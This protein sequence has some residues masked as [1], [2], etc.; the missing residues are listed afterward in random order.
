MAKKRLNPSI[1]RSRTR[2]GCLTCRDRHMKCDE[3]QPVCRNCIKSKRKCYRGIRLN[4]TQYTIYNPRES[5]DYVSSTLSIPTSTP[6]F[7]ILDQSIT[8]ASLYQDGEKSYRPYLHLHTPEDLQEAEL[9][10]RQGSIVTLPTNTSHSL[11]P[12]LDPIIDSYPQTPLTVSNI[13]LQYPQQQDFLNNSHVIMENYDITNL[14]LNDSQFLNQNLQ[15]VGSDYAQPTFALNNQFNSSGYPPL[16]NNSFFPNLSAPHFSPTSQKSIDEG[17]CSNWELINLPDANT[18]EIIIKIIEKQRYYCFL[19]LFNE[20][21]LWKSAIPSYCLF[22][23]N[24]CSKSFLF[25][26]FMLCANEV[27]VNLNEILSE[28]LD[29]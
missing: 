14:L 28:Q 26:C 18:C 25:K 11:D 10:Y 7:R 13:P 5:P 23:L 6:E 27:T 21:N 29:I 8:I 9:Q 17:K 15:S 3:Q 1:K 12:V 20:L 2:S 19:D 24:N 4:F 16:N 22:E